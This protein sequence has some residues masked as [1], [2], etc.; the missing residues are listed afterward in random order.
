M[1]Q[2]KQRKFGFVLVD[3]SDNITEVAAAN[4][5]GTT[6]IFV[7]NRHGDSGTMPDA[8]EAEVARLKERSEDAVRQEE[9]R[10]KAWDKVAE[11]T[12][13]SMEAKPKA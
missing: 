9:D 13:K 1:K 6:K 12:F 5:E 7:V 8:D 11:S 2:M 4:F 3:R 10:E